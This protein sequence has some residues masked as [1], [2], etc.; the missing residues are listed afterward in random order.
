[1]IARIDQSRSVDLQAIAKRERRMVHVARRH[2][3]VFDGET[4]LH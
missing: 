3:D 1:V 2:A 4:S